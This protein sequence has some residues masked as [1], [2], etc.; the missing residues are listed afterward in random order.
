M[1]DTRWTFRVEPG[2][3]G[4]GTVVMIEPQAIPVERWPELLALGTRYNDI[5]WVLCSS[6]PREELHAAMKPFWL[7]YF[8]RFRLQVVADR[9]QIHLL[10]YNDGTSQPDI[11]G[12]MNG[13]EI[14]SFAEDPYYLRYEGVH[15]GGFVSVYPRE[16]WLACG[17]EADDIA[18]ANWEPL[19]SHL[20]VTALSR[21]YRYNLAWF[22]SV[23]TSIGYRGGH[24]LI[25]GRLIFAHPAP[26]PPGYTLT[27]FNLD[28]H[29]RL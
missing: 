19:I 2:S 18:G 20:S 21:E 11:R 3:Q 26:E 29:Y 27:G 6:L 28:A 17:M 13:Q 10:W 9:P 22:V 16:Y 7:D 15:Q 23:M 14:P 4:I 1:P 5:G 12:F 25:D 8:S 24:N